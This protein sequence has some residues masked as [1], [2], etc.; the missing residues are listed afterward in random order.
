[1]KMKP[2]NAEREDRPVG[3][4]RVPAGA[5][6][7]VSAGWL[8]LFFGF[9]LI[10]T[11]VS[12][13]HWAS[14]H[15]DHRDRNQPVGDH[16]P[17]VPLG[18]AGGNMG[19][20]GHHASGRARLVHCAVG[21]DAAHRPCGARHLSHAATPFITPDPPLANL[22][23]V[24]AIMAFLLAFGL[25]HIRGRGL[26]TLS[27][28]RTERPAKGERAVADPLADSDLA[29]ATLGPLLAQRVTIGCLAMAP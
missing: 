4:R 11:I 5:W 21:A 19:H 12:R 25:S 29:P 13:S 24:V 18:R 15:C 6:T 28:P 26:P 1:M 16:L 17:A 14:G 10:W 2:T 27:I 3:R 7:G 22:P 8:G 9:T 23:L 20:A